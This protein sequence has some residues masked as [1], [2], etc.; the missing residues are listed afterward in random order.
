MRKSLTILFLLT[1]F[2]ALG[3]ESTSL[4]GIYKNIDNIGTIEILDNRYYLDRYSTGPHNG[5]S[6]G[7]SGGTLKVIHDH[8][9][10]VNSNR[11]L[12]LRFEDWDEFET[13][14]SKLGEDS[15]FLYIN[16]TN[17]ADFFDQFTCGEVYNS[18][19][20]KNI[21]HKVGDQVLIDV[22]VNYDKAVFETED[23]S[24]TLDQNSDSKLIIPID[25]VDPHFFGTSI[26]IEI[27]L[28]R[29]Y[30]LLKGNTK[31][32]FKVLDLGNNKVEITLPEMN[33]DYFNYL[34]LKDELMRVKKD[35]IF[36]EGQKYVKLN[37]DDKQLEYY[38]S[39]LIENG[40]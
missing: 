8:F 25:P 2:I 34:Y 29:Q 18:I 24:F 40:F 13:K 3:Q 39:K 5:Q 38:K 31:S 11:Q 36:W 26:V 16:F 10:E 22:Y 28:K 19:E 7:S 32:F 9:I 17:Y 14:E 15:K 33:F 37:K 20:K 4:N 6:T 23:F 35:T 27:Y 12:N 1:G 21:P 30:L